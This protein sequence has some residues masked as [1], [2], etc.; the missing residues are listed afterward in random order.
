MSENA[1]AMD[2]FREIG[3]GKHYLGSA[4]TL[5]NFEQAFYR[6]TVA[7]NNSYEQWSAEGNLDTAQRANGLWK[8]MLA[9]YEAPDLDPAID[10][11]LQAYM[12]EQK[13]AFPDRD[14]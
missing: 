6:S 10:E 8:K 2:A 14:Y 12:T 11:A 4:H 9:E 13:A 7:D 5:A 3:P 1:Q